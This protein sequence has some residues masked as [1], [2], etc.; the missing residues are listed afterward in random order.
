MARIELY[1]VQL[2]QWRIAKAKGIKL[3]DATVKSGSHVF[4]PH[5]SDLYAYKQEVIG[6]EE[7]TRRYTEKMRQSWLQHR[8][9]WDT[10]QNAPKLAIACYCKPGAFCHRHL[11]LNFIEAHLKRLGHEVVK[12]GEITKEK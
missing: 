12:M 11:L 5:E 2:A 8:P 3:L 1:T 7:Y 10:L 6:P 4:A 9:I